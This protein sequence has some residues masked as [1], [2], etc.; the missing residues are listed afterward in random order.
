MPSLSSARRRGRRVRGEAFDD[1]A[2]GERAA[3]EPE[4]GDLAQDR[5]RRRRVGDPERPARRVVDPGLAVDRARHGLLDGHSRRSRVGQA[6]RRRERG[7]RALQEGG[8]LPRP[9][10]VVGPGTDCEVRGRRAERDVDRDLAVGPRP[11][12][13]DVRRQVR[14]VRERAARDRRRAVGRR[15]RPAEPACGD[16]D[17]VAGRDRDRDRRSGDPGAAERPDREPEQGRADADD[18][19]RRAARIG[20]HEGEP[21]G[22]RPPARESLGEPDRQQR[23]GRRARRHLDSHP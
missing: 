11:V 1:P 16:S 22:G 10:R 14:R 8:R 21:D 18:P 9:A 7:E 23:G 19:G 13:E 2:V 4:M 12:G 20:Q 15:R 3:V 5:S 17:L 6:D